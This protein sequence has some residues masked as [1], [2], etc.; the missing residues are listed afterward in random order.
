MPGASRIPDNGLVLSIP[1]KGGAVL[2]SS[3]GSYYCCMSLLLVLLLS[4][5]KRSCHCSYDQE[6]AAC[7]KR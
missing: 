2:G 5:L 7:L 4:C 6:A 3:L 1:A